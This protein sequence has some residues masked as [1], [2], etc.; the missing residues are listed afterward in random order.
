MY[1][2]NRMFQSLIG[3]DG[4]GRMSVFSDRRAAVAWLRSERSRGR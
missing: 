1:G 4:E 2:L 3:R